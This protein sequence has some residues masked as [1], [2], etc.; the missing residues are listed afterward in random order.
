YTSFCPLK[1]TSGSMRGTYQMVTDEG[2][3]FDATIAP[4]LLSLHSGILQ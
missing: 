2:E 4:F 1:T 3:S